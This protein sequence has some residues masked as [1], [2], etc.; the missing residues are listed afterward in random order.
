M[1]RERGGRRDAWGESYHAG[2]MEGAASCV[3]R[4]TCCVVHVSEATG[5]DAS[6]ERLV[7]LL[8]AGVRAAKRR[9]P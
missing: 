8:L 1:L 3:L 4:T 7:D 6:F 9:R 5:V 2:R